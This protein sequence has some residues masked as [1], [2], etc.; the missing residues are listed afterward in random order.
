MTCAIKL[1]H[2]HRAFQP[3]YRS[4]CV[5][6]IRRHHK[7]RHVLNAV[8]INYVALARF[9]EE[10][11]NH[12][13]HTMTWLHAQRNGDPCSYNMQFLWWH[14]C[15]TPSWIIWCCIPFAI[16]LP[17]ISAFRPLMRHQ[18]CLQSS[19]GRVLIIIIKYVYSS[20]SCRQITAQSVYIRPYRDRRSGRITACANLICQYCPFLF[21]VS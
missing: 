7:K 18:G 13:F 11:L 2:P 9:L 16:K 6:L 14:R 5:L 3:R 8:C 1:Q 15:S 4:Q 19:T 10:T 20:Y 21:F 12:G 17:C